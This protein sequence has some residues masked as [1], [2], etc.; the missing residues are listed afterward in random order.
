MAKSYREE[1]QGNQK[2]LMIVLAVLVIVFLFTYFVWP[3][4]MR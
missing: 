2:K 4:F 3:G 1:P